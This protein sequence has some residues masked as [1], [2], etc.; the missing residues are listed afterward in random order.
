MKCYIYALLVGVLFPVDVIYAH[1]ISHTAFPVR[2]IKKIRRNVIAVGNAHGEDICQEGAAY[3]KNYMKAVGALKLLDYMI[4]PSSYYRD[5]LCRNYHY[6]EDQTFVFPSGGVNEKFFF[7][8]DSLKCR[9][10]MGFSSDKRYIGFVSRLVEG[11]GWDTFLNAAALFLQR[12]GVETEQYQF[13]MVGEG[14]DLQKVKKMR[15]ELHLEENV[16][17]FPFMPQKKLGDY[18]NALNVFCFPTRRKSESLGLVGL[19][20]MRCG[21]LTLISDSSPGPLTYAKDDVNSL[22]FSGN[23]PESLA[24]KL[25]EVWNCKEEEKERIRQQAI[26]TGKAYGSEPMEEKLRKIFQK[27]LDEGKM[28]KKEE[29]NEAWDKFNQFEVAKN[30]FLAE[31]LEIGTDFLEMGIDHWFQEDIIKEIP[32]LGITVKLGRTITSV[33]DMFFTKKVLTFVKAI[34]DQQLNEE[35]WKKHREKLIRDKRLLDKEIEVIL[36]YL[37]RQTHYRKSQILGKFYSLYFNEEIDWEDFQ[38][39]AEILDA[40][41]VFDFFTLEELYKEKVFV[42]GRKSNKLALKRLSSCGLVDYFN[43][44]LATAEDDQIKEP[45]YAKITEVGSVFVECG[46]TNQD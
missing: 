38:V 30:I 31:P 25:E 16:R 43:G 20:A 7:K 6:P 10:E 34:H 18:F 45:Y 1:Y 4:V 42:Q 13:V 21:T 39:L 35:K 9:E 3:E 40:V 2:V 33:N 23:D 29:Q 37:D 28:I 14:P 8:Q 17:L 5:Y 32:V 19:E 24:E 11:K 44:M 46:L 12:P 41:S 36:I 15:V 27:I 26:L 22:L